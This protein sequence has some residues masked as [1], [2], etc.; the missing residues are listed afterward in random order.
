[1]LF[2]LFVLSGCVN[3]SGKTESM[4]ETTETNTVKVVR[5]YTQAQQKNGFAIYQ[6]YCL[7]C[8]KENATG[9]K[10]WTDKDEN[11]FYPPPALNGHGHTYHHKL[12]NL[13]R[14]VREGGI[15]KGG[16]MPG[17]TGK[18]SPQEID[19]VLAWVQSLWSDDIYTAWLRWSKNDKK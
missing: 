3:S 9:A 17:F 12:D 5:W 11:G 7:E 13:R 16:A 10:N 1:M 8:H 2:S 19:E 4:P 14:S 6:R 15:A 18:L